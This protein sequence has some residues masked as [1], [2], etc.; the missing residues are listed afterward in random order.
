[1][2]G[3]AAT[4][5]IRDEETLKGKSRT[6]IIALTADVQKGIHDQCLA[7]GMDAYL[8]KPFNKSQLRQVLTTWLRHAP[9]ASA[10]LAA[11]AREPIA[12]KQIGPIHADDIAELGEIV[13]A[14][15][16][17]L[18]DKAIGLYRQTTPDAAEK[19]RQALAESNAALLTAAAHSL[20]S[21]SANLG[22]REL[23]VTCQALEKAGK[24]G[25]LKQ[26]EVLLSLFNE[27]MAAVLTALEALLQQQPAS[28]K[29]LAVTP[30][31]QQGNGGVHLL[32]VDDDPNFRLI[33]GEHLRAAGFAV[34][35]AGSGEQALQY[36]QSARPDL[37]LVDAIMEGIDGFET[38]R[39]MR[40]IPAM[41]DVPIIMST[42]LDDIES[43]NR[44]FTAGAA[45]FII[46]PL[47]HA[48]LIHHI[49]FLLRASRDTA[50]L[51]NSKQQ[52][53]TVRCA[54]DCGFGL[55]DLGCRAKQV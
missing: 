46:K 21:A 42:G 25:E 44:A 24:Q 31:E 35:E 1:M 28:E 5:R 50:E 27:Q 38:C 55:L 32:M 51:R 53:A 29:N 20:K 10:H 7:A 37:V 12:H 49:K 54:T 39:L 4:G 43:I 14:Q 26:A 41:A 36:L 3:F 16:V 40:A 17:S 47:N 13:D 33:T 34:E 52:T 22:A 9:E 19:I 23:A 48:V 15:G 8:S 11:V 30:H 45:D 2:D 18:L 6:P